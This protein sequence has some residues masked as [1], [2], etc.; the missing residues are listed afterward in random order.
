MTRCRPWLFVLASCMACGAQSASEPAGLG[1]AAGYDASASGG[2]PAAGSEDTSLAGIAAASNDGGGNRQASLGDSAGMSNA[3]EPG[4]MPHIGSATRNC[5]NEDYCFGLSCYAPPSFEP[6]V[7][8]ARCE[9]DW[10]CEPSETCIRSARLEATCYARCDSPTD[11]AHHFD[12]VDFTGEG[13]AV[14]F[15]TGWAAR[16]EELGN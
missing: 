9:T 14:C 2:A 15:P 8:V 16:R 7:C 6:M 1:G 11:C 10:D 5:E 13:Q 4:Y 3:G 12:C